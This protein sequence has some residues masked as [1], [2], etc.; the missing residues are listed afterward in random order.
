MSDSFEV[1]IGLLI[2]TVIAFVG[3]DPAISQSFA[4]ALSD[5]NFAKSSAAPLWRLM[6]IIFQLHLDIVGMW[7]GVLRAGTGSR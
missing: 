5:P 3:F 1:I 7:L 6:Q 2:V 4:Q